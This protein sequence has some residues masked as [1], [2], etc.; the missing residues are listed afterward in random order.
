[1][2]L[3]GLERTERL[4]FIDYI[5]RQAI[6][7]D[8]DDEAVLHRGCLNSQLKRPVFGSTT[9]LEVHKPLSAGRTPFRNGERV[10]RQTPAKAS[11][12]RSVG[13]LEGPCEPFLYFFLSW[14]APVSA[15][16][17]TPLQR[18]TRIGLAVCSKRAEGQEPDRG[19]C[20]R[21]EK[22]PRLGVGTGAPAR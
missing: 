10:A 3:S 16:L 13:W 7:L 1:V 17:P 8:V 15:E 20:D 19:P 21:P 2:G 12:N 4:L 14:S 11:L 5:L 9:M 6:V 18:P 22:R